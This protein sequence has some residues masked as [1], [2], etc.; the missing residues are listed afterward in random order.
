[1]VPE[2]EA[3]EGQKKARLLIVEDEKIIALD[4]QRRLEKYGY[5]VVSLSDDGEQAVAL[6]EEH[7]PDLV[8]MD[9]MLNGTF[10]GIQAAEAIYTSL[11]IPIIF[12]TAYADQRTIER[13]KAAQPFGYVLKPFK[14]RELYSTIDIALYKS[15]IDKTL[16]KHDRWLNAVLDNIGDGIIAAGYDGTIDYMNPAAQKLSGWSMSQHESN[17]LLA[18]V[19]SLHDAQTR[20]KVP[21]PDHASLPIDRPMFFENLLLIN[22]AGAHIH[23]EGS[24]A[25]IYDDRQTCEGIVVAFQDVT[26]IKTMSDTITYQASHD[27]LTGLINRDEFFTQLK[28][29]IAAHTGP[30]PDHLLYLDIDQFKVI[31]DLCG[32]IAGDQLLHQ[33]S[34]DLRQI[35]PPQT[36]FARMGGDEFGLLVPQMAIEELHSFCIQLLT[37]V[38]RKFT[39]QHN[40]INISVSIGVVTIERSTVDPY[41]VLAAADDATYLS[42][43]SGGNTYRF[44][45]TAELSFLKRRGE[46]QWVARLTKALEQDRF[47]LFEQPIISLADRQIVKHEI[48]LRL[49]DDNGDLISP[50]VFIPAAERY[51]LMPAVD[52]WVIKNTLKTIAEAESAAHYTINLSGASIAD[53]G[54]STFIENRFKEFG[55][56][57]TRFCFEITETTA[58]ENLSMA[59]DFITCM[60]ELGTSFALDDFGSGFS[61]FAYLRNL[62]VQYLKLDGSYV[63][64]IL[65]DPVSMQMVESINAIGHVLGMSTI[66][67]Y[68]RSAEILDELNALGVDLGQGYEIQ[69]PSPLS[70]M[71]AM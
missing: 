45:K 44:Y 17:L 28:D 9:I 61:S 5:D 39:W 51:N 11:Q 3:D 69:K 22:K 1:M 14:E 21:I 2:M 53:K 34:K 29:T 38:R 6:A 55:I 26:E 36:T 64:D 12:L 67:E 13:S 25:G 19:L 15:D 48:L 27:S 56:D 31:N 23:I 54:L 63:K 59:I 42:K 10:D 18:D 20:L 30:I 7:K 24:F 37:S 52:R 47:V 66:A 33:I 68:V 4:L 32:H 50:Q 40:I 57:P 41:S 71:L 62:P 60:R 35:L 49:Q 58:I 43:E 16:K 8:L 70:V 65:T 46:M